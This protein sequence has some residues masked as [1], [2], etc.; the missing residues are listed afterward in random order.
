MGPPPPKAIAKYEQTRAYAYA[1]LASQYLIVVVAAVGSIVAICSLKSL[2][3]SVTAANVQ[4]SAAATQAD[5]VTL[6]QQPYVAIGARQGEFA[7]FTHDYQNKLWVKLHVMNLGQ[8]PALGFNLNAWSEDAPDHPDQHLETYWDDTKHKLVRGREGVPIPPQT[9]YTFLVS[10]DS[11]QEQLD[12]MAKEGQDFHI[13]G[14]LE[15]CDRLERFHCSGFEVS[16]STDRSVWLI[17]SGPPCTVDDLSPKH[18][19]FSIDKDVFVPAPRCKGIGEQS[20]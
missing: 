13:Q 7:Q 9:E 5:A 2:N 17:T 1:Y 8:T 4:A 20:Q 3:D 19:S 6:S 18:A 10:G 11:T 14:T 16:Y 15:Y 12:A